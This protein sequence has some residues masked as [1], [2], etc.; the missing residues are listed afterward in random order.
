MK[1]V[2][3]DEIASEQD[4]V[5][6]SLHELQPSAIDK[7]TLVGADRMIKST[8]QV[9]EVKSKKNVPVKIK[10]DVPKKQKNVTTNDKAVQ[11]VPEKIDIEA[12]DLTCTDLA[13]PSENYWQVLAEK[14]RIALKNTLNENKE[15]IKRLEKLEEEKRIYK[16]MLDETKS[17][18]E[19]LQDMI[20]DDRNDINNSLEDSVL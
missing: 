3:G 10:K 14:R 12:E 2:T 17:L 16:E 4:K 7:E 1:P 5:R 13:G 18:V 6:K 9:K 15:L 19:V 8:Q 20:E 11:T